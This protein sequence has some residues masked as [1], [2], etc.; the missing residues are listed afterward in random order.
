M[1]QRKRDFFIIS[2]IKRGS[3][4][5]GLFAAET[6][7][8]A[9][10][11][12]YTERGINTVSVLTEEEYFHGSL[13]D[14]MRVKERFPHLCVMRKDFILNEEDIDATYRAGA[15]AVL[16]IACM[17]DTVT[18][19]RLYRRAKGLGLEVLFEIHNS[20]DLSKAA[21]V[22]PDVTGINSR[23][24]SNFRTD[25]AIPLYLKKHIDWNTTTVFESGIV[26][27]E[28]AA[29]ALS[30][31]FSG[32]LVGEAAMKDADLIVQITKLVRNKIGDFWFRLFASKPANGPLVK[33]C[34]IT[35]ESDA[36][37]A[38]ELG[39][40]V[41]GFIY[42]PSPRTA[43]I[44][45]PEKVADLE[46]LK[47]AVVVHNSSDRSID[48]GIARLVSEGFIDA[49]QF[50][51]NERPEHCYS[52]AFPYYKALRIGGEED[53]ERIKSYHCPRVLVDAFTPGKVGGTGQRIP[54]ELV[55]SIQTLH[56]LWLAGGIGPDNVADILESHR[57]EL[58][59]ASSR[60]E[61]EPGVKSRSGM[62]TLFRE[63]EAARGR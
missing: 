24:L 57:P 63:I 42:A 59:D 8:V 48:G 4:S 62:K 12:K 23:D 27:V 37:L 20:D 1:M 58:I 32:M 2:E 14:V 26:S 19:S 25:P 10:A 54:S 11:E 6:D 45:L 31:G 56:P 60:L 44:E 61:Q 52:M 47:V 9:Q 49:L 41:L 29:V 39:A 28:D 22:K 51:G 18:L 16:L 15:D 38:A 3:P 53:V 46:Q 55:K 35:R 43:D 33:I 36:R 13:E 30:G 34:G 50:H 5:R 40:Q 7:A 21:S 17:H